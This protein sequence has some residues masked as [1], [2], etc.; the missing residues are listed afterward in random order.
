MI[1][2]LDMDALVLLARRLGSNLAGYIINISMMLRRNPAG[3]RD[4]DSEDLPLESSAPGP[5]LLQ[6]LHASEE[7]V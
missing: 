4:H 1:M 7:D 6:A 2:I 5:H 3:T